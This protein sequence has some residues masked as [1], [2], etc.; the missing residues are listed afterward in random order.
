MAR[1]DQ[2][3]TER[4]R[5]NSDA[6]SGRRNRLYVDEAH[7]D[8]ENYEYRFVNDEPGRLHAFTVKDDWEVVPDRDGT[9]KADSSG[10]GA[11]V[12]A[13]A[14]I[15]LTGA[16]LKTVLLRKPR[17]YYDDDEAAKQRQIDAKEAGLKVGQT[18]GAGVENGY[19]PKGGISIG[20]N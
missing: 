12:S 10:M 20:R 7:L 16:P 18:E 11:E 1:N 19:V 15:G 5:R 6:L 13:H 14:G 4:R 17:K 2:I 3:A 9:M 8:R